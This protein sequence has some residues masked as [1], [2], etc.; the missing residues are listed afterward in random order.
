MKMIGK[1]FLLLACGILWMSG[2]GRQ[3]EDERG[4]QV[5]EPVQEESVA[6]KEETS[7]PRELTKEELREFTAWINT[8]NNYGN[9]GFLLSEYENP[10][11]MDLNELFYTGAGMECERLSPE[12][13]TAYLEATGQAEIYT[14]CTRLTSEQINDFLEQRLG[15]SYEDMTHPLDWVYLPEQDIYVHEHGDTNYMNFTC[16][17]GRQTGDGIYELDCV[18]GDDVYTPYPPSRFTL[19]KTASDYAPV[20]NIYT[21]GITYSMDIWKIEDQCFD[22]DLEGWGT[23]TFA[24]YGQDQSSYGYK[25]AVFRLEKDGETL[26]QFPFVMAENYRMEERFRRILA[27]SFQDYNKDGD[28]DVIL[29]AEYESVSNRDGESSFPEVRLY[30]NRPDEQEF[31]LDVD[32]MDML[33][34]NQ[35]NHTVSE[36]MDH[37]NETWNVEGEQ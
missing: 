10:R 12:E 17:S 18:S 28:K 2:C 37:M 5:Q 4:T 25:D 16:V 19:K 21:E 32:R 30:E 13:Q 14:D 26:Y 27:V 1:M 8:G 34:G 23:V 24:S 20:S 7:F 9:Y 15:L 31:V 6:E 22:V 3:E 11:D 36:V 33:N 29:I 35:W